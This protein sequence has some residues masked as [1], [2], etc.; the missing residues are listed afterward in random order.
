MA[1]ERFQPTKDPLAIV[2]SVPW[3]PSTKGKRGEREESA[4]YTLYLVW[5][6]YRQMMIPLWNAEGPLG[7]PVV[8]FLVLGRSI[9]RPNDSHPDVSW[10]LDIPTLRGENSLA[11]F[12]TIPRQFRATKV[13]DKA[14]RGMEK[15]LR[16]IKKDAQRMESAGHIASL[17]VS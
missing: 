10:A 14:L 5:V 6:R 13:L 11:V 15:V 7:Q 4:P 12:E 16:A 9:F 2:E 3:G 8:T 17:M 1:S